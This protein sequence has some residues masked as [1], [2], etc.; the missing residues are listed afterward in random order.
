MAIIKTLFD[1]VADKVSTLRG[2]EPS[3]DHRIFE[4]LKYAHTGLIGEAAG[5][6]G[7]LIEK[8][9]PLFQAERDNCG[10]IWA[11]VSGVPRA[12]ADD[13]GALVAMTAAGGNFKFAQFSD[14]HRISEGEKQSLS[15]SVAILSLFNKASRYRLSELDVRNNLNELAKDATHAGIVSFM[16]EHIEDLETAAKQVYNDFCAI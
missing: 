15:N 16:R 1:L 12:F 6:L 11:S 3:V 7:A 9:W 13:G 10:L 2:H 4:A 5:M 8:Q 14:T